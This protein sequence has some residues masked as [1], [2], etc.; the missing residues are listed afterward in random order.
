MLTTYR[1]TAAVVAAAS[2]IAFVASTA[3]YIVFAD[4]RAGYLGADPGSPAP[5]TV[6]VELLRSGVL[7]AALALAAAHFRIATAGKALVLGLAVFVAFPGSILVGSVMWDGAPAGLAAIHAGDW[8][9]KLALI[10]LVVS[11]A[12]KRGASASGTSRAG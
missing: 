3:W 9:I 1:R 8:L 5:W 4:Q 10:A 6:L 7:A 2:V 11:L 12:G